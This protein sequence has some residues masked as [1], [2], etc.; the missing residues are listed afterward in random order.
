MSPLVRLKSKNKLPLYLGAVALL[1]PFVAAASTVTVDYSFNLGGNAGSGEVMFD[2]TLATSDAD[3][4]F[5]NSA[6]GLTEF[7]LT[8]LGHTYTMTDAL[9]FPTAPEVFLPG[10]N[11]HNTIPAGQIGLF[12]FWVVPGSDSGG[13]ESLIGVNRLGQV[14]LYTGVEDSS[15]S[16]LNNSTQDPGSTLDNPGSS[17]TIGVCPTQADC[18]NF[19]ET[20]GAITPEPALIPLMGL[21]LAGLLI[22]RR[23]LAR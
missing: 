18:P 14:K 9:D 6:N 7:N 23:K 8:Y 13:F 3:G 12:G 11:Y 16:F 17:L 19:K 21:G 4:P 2:P 5:A 22:A 15:I 1:L 10:N 20:V